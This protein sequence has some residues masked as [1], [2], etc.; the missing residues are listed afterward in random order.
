[1]DCFQKSRLQKSKLQRL[2]F[3]KQRQFCLLGSY[4]HHLP[5]D[6]NS[7]WLKKGQRYEETPALLMPGF[8][9]LSRAI[10]F[11]RQVR[12]ST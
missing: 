10:L 8:S 4:G 6:F 1:M 5:P 3:N 2:R 9:L 7:E 12:I 11:A